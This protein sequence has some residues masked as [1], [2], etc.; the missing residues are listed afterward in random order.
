MYCTCCI[1]HPCRHLWCCYPG[2]QE[3]NVAGHSGIWQIP[4]QLH[5]PEKIRRPAPPVQLAC[6]HRRVEADWIG[7]NSFRTSCETTLMFSG[8]QVQLQQNSWKRWHAY[9]SG[10]RVE[11]VAATTT[12]SPTPTTTPTTSTPTPTPAAEATAI[13]KGA[14]TNVLD[15]RVPDPN[16]HEVQELEI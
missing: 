8:K 10:R 14:R 6:P 12:T 9:L 11:Y 16:F 3:G 5:G 15:L 1:Y 4:G 7:Q 13:A 2:N